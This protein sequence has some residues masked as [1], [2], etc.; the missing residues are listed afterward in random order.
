[1][2]KFKTFVEEITNSS[3]YDIAESL[4]SNIPLKYSNTNDKV[5]WIATFTVDDNEYEVKADK[6][7]PQP[8]KFATGPFGTGPF[9]EKEYEINFRILPK[10]QP[11]SFFKKLTTPK[12]SYTAGFKQTNLGTPTALKVLSAVITFTK[13]FIKDIDPDVIHLR[14]EKGKGEGA[15]SSMIKKFLPNT[16]NV[17]ATDKGYCTEYKITKNQ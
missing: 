4:D 6:V 2:K 9:G 12:P 16:Y 3:T 1:M 14:V 5:E 10:N 13:K 17:S 7:V 15:Y 11:T 8:K